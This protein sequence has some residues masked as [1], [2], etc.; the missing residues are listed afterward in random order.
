MKALEKKEIEKFKHALAEQEGNIII[1]P[2]INPDGDAIGSSLGLTRVLRNAGYNVQAITPNDCPEFISWIEGSTDIITYKKEPEKIEQLLE[3][4]S[5]L[6]CLDFNQTSRTGD[7]APLLEKFEGT[8]VLIDHHPYPQGF[9]TLQ[10]SQ[11]DY[12]ST[13]ELVLHLLEELDLSKYID[14]QAAEALYCGILTDTGSF[15]HGVSDPE[16]FKS[17]SRLISYGVEPEIIHRKVFN[18]Y[19]ADR[20]KLMGY[21]LNEC[22]EII[23]EYNTAIIWLSLET[24]KK[25]NYVKGDS[26]GFVNI[27]LSIKGIQVSALFTENEHQIKGSLRSQGDF[28]VNQIASEHFNG[29]G[30]RNAAGCEIKELSLMETVEKFKS[31]LPQYAKELEATR[32]S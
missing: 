10:F 22:M 20:M 18:N 26:E 21:C 1:I 19:S 29:G 14:K 23:P 16:T 2:H 6:L 31:L 11:P 12:S 4:A 28:A 15:N 32:L 9:T 13:C 7:V 8:S 25:F 30:H 24:Q 17:V 3:Q 27:P 5:M